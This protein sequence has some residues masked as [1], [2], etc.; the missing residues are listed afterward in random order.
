MN[1]IIYLLFLLVAAILLGFVAGAFLN[2][3][4]TSCTEMGCFCQEDGELSCN[5]CKH[6]NPLFALGIL[7]I[8]EVCQA[9]EIFICKEGEMAQR[10]YDIT[11]ECTTEAKW[12]DFV[13][14]YM[15]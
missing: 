4:I 13:L 1:K 11:K 14:N 2:G 6:E 9:K 5:T 10:R 12:F 3:G 8:I 15:E 7:N